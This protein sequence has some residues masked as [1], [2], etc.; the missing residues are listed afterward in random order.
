MDLDETGYVWTLLHEA[1][2]RSLIEP[3]A[4]VVAGDSDGPAVAEVV[5]IVD[6]RREI[7]L[8]IEDAEAALH[9]FDVGLALR[10]FALD[11]NNVRRG[12]SGREQGTKPVGAGLSRFES[13]V[14]IDYLGGDVLSLGLAPED[15][16]ERRQPAERFLETL[17]GH[18]DR[19][20][21]LVLAAQ[22]A[23]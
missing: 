17:R 14:Q 12:A 23:I 15:S 19:E 16:S 21:G 6:N 9:R 20:P 22:V 2:D 4:I 1:R 3:D 5:D 18:L 13:T 10:Q 11:G 7:D 8:V